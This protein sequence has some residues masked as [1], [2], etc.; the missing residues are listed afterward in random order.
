[1]IIGIDASRFNLEKKT[2]VEVYSDYIISNIAKIA[3]AQKKHKIILYCKQNQSIPTE[4]TDTKN[5]EIK[6]IKGKRLWTQFRLSATLSKNKPDVLFIPSHVLPIINGK[7]NVITIHDVAFMSFPEVYSL[8]QR[9][10]LKLTTKKACKKANTIIVPSKATSGDLIKYFK[11]N[12]EKIKIIY[13]GLDASTLP[14]AKKSDDAAPYILFIGRLESKK[15]LIRL[16]KA[17]NNFQKTH[18]D[19]KLILAGPKAVGSDKI[20]ESIKDLNLE[21]KVET[22]GY[23][24]DIE[25]SQLLTNAKIFA[26][27]S[28]AEGFGFPILEAFNY[29]IPVLTSNSSSMKEIGGE[30]ALYINPLD[31]TEIQEGLEKLA[32]N[33]E[34]VN[35]LLQKQ[36]AIL[37][38]YTWQESAEKTWN[39]LTS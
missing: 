24:T 39:V 16:L 37:K 15:N 32:N 28:L 21:N 11:C 12:P 33:T 18:S 34:L 26:F 29:K 2:G 10:Y 25:K 22:P 23:I 36:P 13:H 9:F 31:T 1:M 38:K 8:K 35:K 20:Y 30:G 7:K 4:I 14:K 6:R 17:F 19:W 5:I 27:P 3:S